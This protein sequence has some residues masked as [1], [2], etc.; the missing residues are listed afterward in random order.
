MKSLNS[1][2]PQQEDC[3]VIFDENGQALSDNKAA[4]NLLGSYYQK[5]SKLNFTLLDKDKEIRARKIVHG[6]RS[7]ERGNPIFRDGFT[8]EELNLALGT[9]NPNKSPG[10]DNIHGL[11]ISRLS[12]RG[13]QSL[14]EIFNLSWKL[15]RLSRDWKGALIIPIRKPNKKASSSESYRPIALTNFSCKLMEKLILERL[16]F[17]LDSNNLFP[18]EQYGFRRGHS[19]VDQIL[20]F[21]QRV[22]DSQNLKPSYH[23]IAVFLDLTKAFDRV[24]RN[25]LIIKLSTPLISRTELSPGFMTS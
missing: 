14:L 6:C 11:M 20:Y 1:A 3:N 7:S 17:Y 24:W 2:Q 8:M 22:R 25:G 23:T 5:K 9:L 4:A 13:K 10:P 18:S 19:T 15:G 12:N 21:R 16:T